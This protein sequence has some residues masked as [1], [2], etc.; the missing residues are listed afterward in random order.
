MA[1]CLLTCLCARLCWSI[2]SGCIRSSRFGN[3]GSD[4]E[5]RRSKM[6][7]AQLPRGVSLMFTLAVRDC[8]ENKRESA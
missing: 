2:S 6:E 8:R 1:S 7:L 5:L 4:C 3:I